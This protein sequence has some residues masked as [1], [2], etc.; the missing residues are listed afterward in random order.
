MAKRKTR[1]TDPCSTDPSSK[2]ARVEAAEA[3]TAPQEVKNL[4][5][6][7]SWKA[8]V[9]VAKTREALLKKV[10]QCVE[11]G[12]TLRVKA[13][14]WSCNE[15][16]EP[17]QD[18][19]VGVNVMLQGDF[20]GVLQLDQPEGTITAGAGTQRQGIYSKLDESRRQLVASGEC[21]TNDSSQEVGGLIA[22]AVHDTMQRA[23]SPETVHSLEALVFENGV[24]VIKKFSALDGDAYF[25]FF[26]G[27]G[28]T[29]IIV[30]ATLHCC[31]KKYY[32]HRPYL[33][34]SNYDDDESFEVGTPALGMQNLVNKYYIGKQGRAGTTPGENLT[35]ENGSYDSSLSNALEDLVLKHKCDKE[36]VCA[37]FF[38]FPSPDDGKNE[39]ADGKVFSVGLG[40]YYKRANGPIPK[41]TVTQN[42]FND[43]SALMGKA[44]LQEKQT[45]DALMPALIKVQSAVADLKWQYANVMNSNPQTKDD[46]DAALANS[47]WAYQES[48]VAHTTGPLYVY[49]WAKATEFYINETDIR[50][51]VAILQPAVEHMMAGAK[52]DGNSFSINA[53]CRYAFGSDTAFMSGFYKSNKLAIDIGCVKHQFSN[54]LYTE[55]TMTVLNK[56]KEQ[57]IEVRIHT[58][59]F[60]VYDKELTHYMYDEETRRR[61]TVLTNKY[62]PHGVFAPK[63]WRE[64]FTTDSPAPP[65]SDVPCIPDVPYIPAKSSGKSLPPIPAPFTFPFHQSSLSN[66]GV[67]FPVPKERVL[68]YLSGTGLVPAL[69][70]GMALVSFNFQLYTGR[71]AAGPGD[72][73]E[74]WPPTN[75][76]ITQEV[77]LCIVA[78]P[79]TMQHLVA[80]VSF[81]QFVLGDEQ[82]K[83]MGNHRVHVPCKYISLP[84]LQFTA[85]MHFLSLFTGA[86]DTSL[87]DS[88]SLY[89]SSSFYFSMYTG[90]APIAIQAGMEVF[91]EP[92]FRTTFNVNLATKN[93][94]RKDT[95][96]FQP[97]WSP[98]WGFRINDPDDS[99]KSIC[100]CTFEP[101]GLT[102]VPAN[103]SPIT[104]YGT[105]QNKMI[106]CRWNILQPMDTYLLS[107]YKSDQS[108][109]KLEFGESSHPM[110]V[111]MKKLLTG[112]KPR[113]VRI[114]DSAPAAIQS[115]AYYPA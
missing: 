75:A 30:S 70:D 67:Y 45:M 27:M 7:Y 54:E 92:K 99:S 10:S 103:F 34:G 50:P 21:F 79:A 82:T 109:L 62:D 31:P 32:H 39:H 113:A 57:G 12:V 11:K 1:S 13:S 64:L 83:L 98:T 69:L 81:E 3:T 78:V 14:G 108:R 94:T 68:P 90:D 59:K 28:M 87:V 89:S 29:G 47:H 20:I 60:Y 76:S 74:T 115:R 77:E 46:V 85:W 51:F 88:H 37:M 36:D 97:V 91:G 106:A 110:Q 41:Y 107:E 95:K 58:G 49:L 26:G 112:A 35:V 86:A 2:V 42:E 55:M 63:K 65:P 73:P 93:C 8:E 52:A 40:R 38:A 100:T 22:N 44:Y 15:F 111:D 48:D 114:F 43:V 56:C 17:S 96:I 5:E 9:F 101:T 105:H 71:F 66:F 102:S 6:N 104:E 72:A 24:P 84:D 25:A 53:D 16:I 33:P 4:P 18:G 61:F 80:N 19:Q 23:F